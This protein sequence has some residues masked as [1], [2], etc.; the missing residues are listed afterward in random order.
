MKAVALLVAVCGCNQVFDLHATQLRDVDGSVTTVIVD[1]PRELRIDSV[2]PPSII[3]TNDTFML[4]PFVHGPPNETALYSIET[5]LGS[6]MPAQGDIALDG[7]GVGQIMAMYRA[8][9]APGNEMVTFSAADV[10]AMAMQQVAFAVTDLTSIGLDQTSAS[11]EAIN[12]N[13][14]LGARIAVTSASAVK[15]LGIY[16]ATV[17]TANTMVKMGLYS[18]K[19]GGVPDVRYGFTDAAPLAVGRNEYALTVPVLIQPGDYYVIAVFSQ[20][21]TIPYITS[22]LF[23]V[24]SFTFSM[25]MG[26]PWSGSSGNWIAVA[27]KTH[28]MFMRAGQ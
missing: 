6:I 21:V 20:N 16:A 27:N 2:T 4:S 26:N 14:A 15:K 3:N 7:N 17:P 10:E 11:S 23:G 28:C 18:Y 9:A 13:T 8:P 1:A 22:G 19:T 5:T 12:A 24:Q 25:A